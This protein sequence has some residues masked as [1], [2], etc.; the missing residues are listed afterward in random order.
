MTLARIASLTFRLTIALVIVCRG[1]TPAEAQR[2]KAAGI[3]PGFLKVR[4]AEGA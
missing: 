4:K 2:R 3:K 1:G